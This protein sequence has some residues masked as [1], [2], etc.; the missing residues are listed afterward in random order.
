MFDLSGLP[1]SHFQTFY[2]EPLGRFL[3]LTQHSPAEKQHTHLLAVI[4][5]LKMRRTLIMPLGADA[6]SI[7]KQKD[8]WT[9]AVFVG[10]LMFNAVELFS[11]KLLYRKKEDTRPCEW[12]P[13][14]GAVPKGS[15]YR[16]V[17]TQS[18]S[19][20]MVASILPSIFCKQGLSWLYSQVNV[21][22]VAIELAVSPKT[23]S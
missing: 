14:D 20:L 22:N 15:Q 18:T 3:A 4:K 19:P 8:L 13:F 5:A 1:Q 21:F 23:V 16:L 6:E 11:G 9:Y 17:D 2:K 10:A 7:S 12:S